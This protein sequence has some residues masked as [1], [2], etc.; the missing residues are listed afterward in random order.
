M[1]CGDESRS[2]LVSVVFVYKSSLK[3]AELFSNCTVVEQRALIG[4]FVVRRRINS[5]ICRRMLAIRKKAQRFAVQGGLFVP[6]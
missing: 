4:F 1:N 2:G 3:M 5:E 6:R